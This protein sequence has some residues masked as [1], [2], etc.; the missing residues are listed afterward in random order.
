FDGAVVVGNKD[1]AQLPSKAIQYLTLP[2]PRLALTGGRPGD[3]LAGFAAAKPGFVGIEI[4]AEDG[5]V[6]AIEHLRRPWTAAELAAPVED[7][8]PSV[9]RRVAEFASERWQGV[10]RDRGEAA[11]GR[12]WAG[13]HE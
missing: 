13:A 9:S 12:G 11:A 6:R 2:I 4:G 8:W 7:A 5:P 1:P 10:A 3:E